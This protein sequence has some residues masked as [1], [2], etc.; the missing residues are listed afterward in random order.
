MTNDGT[1]V[2]PGNIV[3]PQLLVKTSL[4]RLE[5]VA[6]DRLDRVGRAGHDRL[7]VVVRLEV[8][9]HVVGERAR[10]ATLGAAHTDSQAEKLLRAE[11]LCDRPEPVVTCEPAARSRLEAAEI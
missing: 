8:R 3:A 9:E 11:L 4:S 2:P 6:G 7:R 5:A 10:V 1:R